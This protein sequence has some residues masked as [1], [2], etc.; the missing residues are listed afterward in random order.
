[1]QVKQRLGTEV[2]RPLPRLSQPAAALVSFGQHS[3]AY[4]ALN[5]FS[6]PLRL[7]AGHSAWWSG[8]GNRQ[9]EY[10]GCAMAFSGG[11][12]F[13]PLPKLLL[14]VLATGISIV[15]IS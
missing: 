15:L 7:L 12:G 14:R 9:D 10:S 2:G 13:S 5:L 6:A 3:V 11:I 1:M 4:H 8:S